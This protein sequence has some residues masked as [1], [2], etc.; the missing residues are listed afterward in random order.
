[1]SEVVPLYVFLIP[2]QRLSLYKERVQILAAV[3]LWPHFYIFPIGVKHLRLKINLNLCIK[4]QTVMAGL[5]ATAQI[6]AQNTNVLRL[7]IGRAP[8][9]GCNSSA[10]FESPA[11]PKGWPGLIC[12]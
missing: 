5:D 2:H 3:Q 11:F 10:G 9:C 7:L 1:M 12:T 4:T 6:L 8:D